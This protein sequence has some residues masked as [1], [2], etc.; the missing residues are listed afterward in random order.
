MGGCCT[1]YGSPYTTI[2]SELAYRCDFHDEQ[3]SF[4]LG[5]GNKKTFS[6]IPRFSRRKE[7]NGGGIFS[8]GVIL[9]RGE[10]VVGRRRRLCKSHGMG[11][12]KWGGGRKR[13]DGLLRI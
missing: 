3:K 12:W 2:I 10:I 9:E 13:N 6:A 1:L 5:R 8:I 7:R 11:V 4:F